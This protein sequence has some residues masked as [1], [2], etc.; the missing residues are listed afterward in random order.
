MQPNDVFM[1]V[2]WDLTTGDMVCAS[3][4]VRQLPSGQVAFDIG[5]HSCESIPIPHNSLLTSFRF[6][7]PS[8]DVSLPLY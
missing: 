4:K 2:D 8:R 1:I 6:T 7:M 3:Y 5:H